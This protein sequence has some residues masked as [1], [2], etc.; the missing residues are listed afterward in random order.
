[1]RRRRRITLIA[2]LGRGQ[3]RSEDS[4]TEDEDEDEETAGNQDEEIDVQNGV[5]KAEPKRTDLTIETNFGRHNP[6]SLRSFRGFIIP[7]FTL[8]LNRWSKPG[9]LQSVS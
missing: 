6:S 5:A 1:M 4:G 2:K 7:E 8:F 9:I 3:R